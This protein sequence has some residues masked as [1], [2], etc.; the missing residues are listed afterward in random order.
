MKSAKQKMNKFLRDDVG[1]IERESFYSIKSGGVSD[2]C[3]IEG[4]CDRSGQQAGIHQSR[5]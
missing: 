2:G 1:F 4:E 5:A 3:D